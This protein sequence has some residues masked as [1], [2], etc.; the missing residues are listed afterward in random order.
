MVSCS[1]SDASAAQDCRI[2]YR[3]MLLLQ[4]SQLQSRYPGQKLDPAA[5]QTCLT[6]MRA[7]L[8]DCAPPPPG[9]RI[10]VTGLASAR[11][12]SPVPS[13]DVIFVGTQ[14]QGEM[15]S[16][17][18]DCAPG[19]ACDER[20]YTCGPKGGAGDGCGPEAGFLEC[21]DGLFC[22][23]ST[24]TVRPRAGEACV[25]GWCQEGLSCVYVPDT[26]TDTCLAPHALDADC[27]DGAG[28]VAGAFCDVAGTQ[29]CTALLADGGT[30]TSSSQC[31]H[32]WCNPYD[33]TCAN[34]GICTFLGSPAP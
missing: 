8:G 16:Y 34:P 4:F 10:T 20:T 18:E 1:C 2:A 23:G 15:C 28:C 25:A 31:L 33:S 7:E 6:D 30:C 24:C 14:T 12:G 17:T 11:R 26:A 29:A 13:C 3:E 27:S 21:Q 5:A 32:A 22:F 9:E 19:L